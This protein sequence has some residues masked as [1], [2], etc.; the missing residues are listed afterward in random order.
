MIYESATTLAKTIIILFNS[1]SSRI[2]YKT[3]AQLIRGCSFSYESSGLRFL[4]QSLEAASSSIASFCVN[5]LMATLILDLQTINND[6]YFTVLKLV[7]ITEAKQIDLTGTKLV[8]ITVTKLIDITFRDSKLF[9]LTLNT[10]ETEDRSLTASD[11]STDHL[12]GQRG[13]PSEKMG[14]FNLVVIKWTSRWT[15][16]ASTP[17]K[18]SNISSLISAREDIDQA[19]TPG[20]R[21]VKLVMRPR[22]KYRCSKR[23]DS[24]QDFARKL[25]SKENHGSVSA[26]IWNKLHRSLRKFDHR[27]IGGS[28]P[29]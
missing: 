28:L 22:D 9:N 21:T 25:N 10:Q 19:L 23:R 2:L 26:L 1:I 20:Q 14:L 11:R 17:I 18:G 15:S 27:P 13:C 3:F 16:Q 7:D 4:V 8:D 12:S 29:R 24:I 6:R 5:T